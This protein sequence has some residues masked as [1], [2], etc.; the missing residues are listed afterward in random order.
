MILN[1]NTQSIDRIKAVLSD[2]SDINLQTIS[3]L[4][5]SLD[6]G[7][8]IFITKESS[9][10]SSSDITFN[11][12]KN[13]VY[14]IKAFPQNHCYWNKCSFCGINSKYEGYMNQTWNIDSLIK[15]INKMFL[16]GIKKIWFLDEAIPVNVLHD[17]AE[18]LITN[19]INI[20]WHIRARIDPAF[21]DNSF[22]KLLWQAGLRHIL[23]GFE[24]ASP[25]ILQLAKKTNDSFNYLEIA[26]KIVQNITFNK[27]AVHFLLLLVFLRRV[28]RN[29]MKHVIFYNIYSKHMNTFLIM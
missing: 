20:I 21:I 23:F 13:K 4:I 28:K 7:K 19:D 2:K 3:D 24:S 10:L 26:E 17:F 16:S 11:I 27:I 1:N 12:D 5:Y 29:G 25:R 6:N 14:N 15:R 8:T 22:V 9:E 18:Q